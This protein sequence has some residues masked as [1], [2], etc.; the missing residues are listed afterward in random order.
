MS[1]LGIY[2]DMSNEDYHA[3]IDT[4]SRSAL[5]MYNECPKLFWAHYVNPLRPEKKQTEAM[6]FG[7]AY[8]TLILEPDTFHHRYAIKPVSVLK[9]DVG[10]PLY[11]AYKNACEALDMTHKII[12][13]DK[14]WYTL[15]AMQAVLKA[16]EEANALIAGAI[17]EQSYFWQDASGLTLKARPDALHKNMIVDLKTISS[18][19]SKTYQRAMYT[20]GYH[21]QGAIIRDA[22]RAC[23]GRTINNVLNLCQEKD[24]PYL[25]GIKLISENALNAGEKFY[26]EICVDLNRAITYND[27][28]T[29]AIDTVDLPTWI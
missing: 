4:Y 9:K 3:E 15:Q 24:Y 11:R 23:E 12:L 5:M 6:I 10:E 19:D 14:D 27:Y 2:K 21:V 20:S 13:S 22:V 28:P 16:D 1:S 17:Y 7:S 18:A 25:I 29:Y 8:H 26:K